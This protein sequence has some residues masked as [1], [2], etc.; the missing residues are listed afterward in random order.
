MIA[1]CKNMNRLKPHIALILCNAIWAI[2]YPFYHIVLKHGVSPSAML[3]LSLLVAAILSFVPL[4]WSKGERVERGDVK[5][6]VAAAILSGLMRKGF[7]IFGLSHTSPIDASIIGTLL[8]VMALVIS[9]TMGVDRFTPKRIIGI[10]L[11]MGGV[12]AIIL[13]SGGSDKASAA[14]SGDISML[15]YTIAAGFYM[16][17]LQPIFKKYK[18]LTQLHWIY[19]LSTIMFFPFALEPTLKIPFATM[20]HHIL[21]LTIFVTVIPT[22]IP[23]LLLNYALGKV[24]PTISSIYSYLQPILA[25]AVSL[26]LGVAKLHWSTL[27]FGAIIITGVTLVLR[28]YSDKKVGS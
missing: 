23:N 24:T 2:N 15:L 20:P 13:N 18:P 19:T 3:F 4:L 5:Y 12:M 16:V 14:L 26:W 1:H 17:W 28:S 25:I 27:L 11:G 21:F 6:L 7:V 22:F 8:P 10:A 9:V